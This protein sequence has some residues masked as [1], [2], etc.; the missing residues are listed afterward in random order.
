[1]IFH[2]TM[3]VRVTTVAT[4]VKVATLLIV[5]SPPLTSVGPLISVTLMVWSVLVWSVTNPIW[6]IWSGVT[7][8][9]VNLVEVPDLRWSPWSPFLR[10]QNTIHDIE[11]SYYLKDRGVGFELKGFASISYRHIS[12]ERSKWHDQLLV[13]RVSRDRSSGLKIRRADPDRI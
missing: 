10:H 11:H 12:I 7:A 9:V 13:Q 4:S 6:S 8:L 3:F 2:R 1:M 5:S